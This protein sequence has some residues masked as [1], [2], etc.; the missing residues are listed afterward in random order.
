MLTI[1]I[2]LISPLAGIWAS[3][4]PRVISGKVGMYALGY[5]ALAR[6]KRRKV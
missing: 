5:A 4:A 3:L 2:F 1:V 6:L